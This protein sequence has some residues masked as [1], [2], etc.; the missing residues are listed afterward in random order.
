MI[1]SG[2][3]PHAERPLLLDQTL[4]TFVPVC[5]LPVIY[6]ACKGAACECLAHLT[7]TSLAF[8]LCLAFNLCEKCFELRRIWCDRCLRN[9]FNLACRKNTEGHRLDVFQEQERAGCLFSHLT[10]NT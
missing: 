4:R 1:E 9:L 5:H 6:C 3:M 2:C 7:E 8:E 10:K